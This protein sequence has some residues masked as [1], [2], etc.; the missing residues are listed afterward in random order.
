MVNAY[1]ALG[2]GGTPGAFLVEGMETIEIIPL[3]DESNSAS[4][5]AP[6]LEDVQSVPSQGPTNT[7]EATAI[8][9]VGPAANL[10]LDK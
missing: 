7:D 9:P 8:G 4:A 2:G 10:Q 5:N 6:L 3:K 1:Q